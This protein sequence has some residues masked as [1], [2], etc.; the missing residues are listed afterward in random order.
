MSSLFIDQYASGLLQWTK[1]HIMPT[2]LASV[3]SVV[4]SSKV[5]W[6]R[7]QWSAKR[8]PESAASLKFWRKTPLCISR[9]SANKSVLVEMMLK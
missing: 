9:S 2:N 3:A 4:G 8:H 1:P 5:V 6:R 7:I